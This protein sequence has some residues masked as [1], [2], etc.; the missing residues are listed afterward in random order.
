[1]RCFQCLAIITSVIIA[2]PLGTAN[3]WSLNRVSDETIGFSIHSNAVS[4]RISLQTQGVSSAH[5]DP[6][7][8][9][10][11]SPESGSFPGWEE[12]YPAQ[13]YPPSNRQNASLTVIDSSTGGTLPVLFG[14]IGCSWFCNETSVFGT[15]NGEIGWIPIHSSGPSAR[16]GAAFASDP[17][18]GGALLYGGRNNSTFFSDTWLF[19]DKTE[20]WLPLKTHN[21]PPALAFASMV[22]DPSLGGAILFGGET[23]S[24]G[25]SGTSWLYIDGNWTRVN[26]SGGPSARWGASLTFD[27][28]SGQVY[29][30]G[31]TNGS[32]IFSNFWVLTNDTWSLI[33]T[34]SGPPARFLA[35]S[36]STVGGYPLLFGGFGRNGPLN[37]TWM[38]EVPNGSW[39]NITDLLP[40]GSSN[41]APLG[42]GQLAPFLTDNLF[43]LTGEGMAGSS[44]MVT[45]LLSVPEG[46]TQGGIRA[47]IA[48]TNSSGRSPYTVTFT[49]IVSGGLPPYNYTWTLGIEHSVRYGD[50]VSYTFV[51]QTEIQ[52]PVSLQVSDSK[53]DRVSVAITVLLLPPEEEGPPTLPSWV[54]DVGL[55]AAIG[56]LS[57][58]VASWSKRALR[59]AHEFAQLRIALGLPAE[60]GHVSAIVAAIRRYLNGGTAVNLVASVLQESEKVA[61]GVWRGIRTVLRRG[62]V[63]GVWLARNLMNVVAKLLFVVTFLFL[64]FQIQSRITSGGAI[65]FLESV[66]LWW[67]QVQQFFTGA[68]IATPY[69]LDVSGGGVS[70]PFFEVAASTLELAFFGLLLSVAISYP[71]GMASGWFRGGKVDWS[72]RFYS[73]VGMYFPTVVLSFLAIGGT[74]LFWVHATGDFLGPFGILP[75]ADWFS[76]NMGRVPSWVTTAGTTGPTGFPLIDG[77]LHGAWPFEEFVLIRTLF[78]GALIALVYSSMYLRYLRLSTEDFREQQFIR[79]ARA[80]GVSDQR[81]LWSHATR[82]SLVTYIATF[83]STFSVFLLT[84]ATVELVFVD[85]GVGSAVWQSFLNEDVGSL[86]PLVY[87]FVLAVVVVNVVADGLIRLLDPRIRSSENAR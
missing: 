5:L 32:G 26:V 29:L 87:T 85:V 35:A 45:W 46:G 44:Q 18:V 37:D 6:N 31:G 58:G 3:L 19:S 74:Y 36:T 21:G 53:G 33:R 40:A 23:A 41:P 52:E 42:G 49:A 57:L 71:L 83:T 8:P 63:G 86:I 4:P 34:S 27:S 60:E 11:T 47:D 7:H 24:G 64:L 78:Q 65:P 82:Y 20:Q 48:T 68:W 9:N 22:Y 75:P 81:L 28:T 38:Y 17:V 77:I 14:G 69:A 54:Y 59:R 2:I 1:M 61:E 70:V 80:R 16:E 72:T 25:A 43:L 76:N 56:V 10:N 30:M 73:V 66:T 13:N 15:I 50:R 67:A 12:L 51:G 55:I 84:V 39:V 62:R 79:S